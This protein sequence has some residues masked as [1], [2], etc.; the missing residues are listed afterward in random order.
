MLVCNR[1]RTIVKTWYFHCSWFCKSG[2]LTPWSLP[3]S[4]HP[5]SPLLI[6]SKHTSPLQ[7][8]IMLLIIPVTLTLKILQLTVDS[9]LTYNPFVTHSMV[10]IIT[11]FA[12]LFPAYCSACITQRMYW[13]LHCFFSLRKTQPEIWLVNH[14]NVI[15][16][17]VSFTL[18]RWV[19]Q[20]KKTWLLGTSMATWAVGGGNTVHGHII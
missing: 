6:L 17:F 20:M 2:G 15:P 3:S 5:V 10:F 9:S 7:F 1:F 12:K 11:E 4:T 18:T 16:H 14:S 19:S 8:L 13:W